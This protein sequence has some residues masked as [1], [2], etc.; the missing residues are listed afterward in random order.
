MAKIEKTKLTIPD[1]DTN[2]EMMY[3]ELTY[4]FR[5]RVLMRK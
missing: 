4:I 2:N 3:Y 5:L 1:S